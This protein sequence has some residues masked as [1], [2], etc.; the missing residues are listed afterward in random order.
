MGPNELQSEPEIVSESTLPHVY[1]KDA[2]PGE[3]I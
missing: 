3:D 1:G 2:Y